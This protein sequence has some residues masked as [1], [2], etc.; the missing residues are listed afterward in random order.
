MRDDATFIEKTWRPFLIESLSS[1]L[2]GRPMT[3]V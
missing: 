2:D 3:S 1:I